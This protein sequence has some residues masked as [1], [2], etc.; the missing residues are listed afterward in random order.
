MTSTPATAA[1]AGGLNP[2]KPRILHTAYF[3]ADIDRALAFYT[4][5]LGMEK[6]DIFDLPEGVKEVVL[7]FPESKGAGVILMWNTTRNVTYT[8][9]NRYSR[10]VMMVADLDA[11]VAQLRAQAVKFT[12]GIVD[13]GQLRYS[14]IE[15][16]DGYAIEL[17]Q[18]KR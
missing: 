8:P 18:F 14:M 2:L 5:V 12:S 1:Q 9:G 16:P 15:D 4:G 7:R 3:V 13:A 11:A 6:L 17:V 10:F